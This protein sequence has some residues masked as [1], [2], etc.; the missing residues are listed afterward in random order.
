MVLEFP[1]KLLVFF[2]FFATGICLHFHSSFSEKFLNSARGELHL[3][4]IPSQEG[5]KSCA[6]L[7]PSPS[8]CLQI[9]DVGQTRYFSISIHLDRA[10]F[11]EVIPNNECLV[12]AIPE[13]H[14]FPERTLPDN[15][16]YKIKLEHCLKSAEDRKL[17]IVRQGCV[18]TRDQF[19]E[20]HYFPQATKDAAFYEV[21]EQH[22]TIYTHHF[23]E[24]ICTVCNKVCEQKARLLIFGSLNRVNDSTKVTVR[25]FMCS[26]LYSIDIFRQVTLMLIL[27]LIWF[28]RQLKFKTI[29]CTHECFHIVLMVF[30]KL[31]NLEK[32][33]KRMLIEHIFLMVFQ[34]LI[35]LEKDCK[36]MLIEEGDVD[37]P[38][39]ILHYRE[40]PIKFSLK[41][42]PGVWELLCVTNFDTGPPG[43]FT[44]VLFSLYFKA[45]AHSYLHNILAKCRIVGGNKYVG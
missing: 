16:F 17:L 26:S 25:P 33:C 29:D 41:P 3:Y 38:R 37:L 32:V 23:T 6:I 28:F 7:N 9:P 8:V 2:F 35:N 14:S 39:D 10:Q 31:I 19:E 4:Y 11:A 43:T 45:H 15:K 1:G 36:R 24:F 27:V 13:F 22:I 12:A 21:D 5:G 18:R 44:R 20:I 42:T 30:Q 40:Y 34:K